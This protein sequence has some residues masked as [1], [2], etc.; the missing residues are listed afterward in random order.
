MQDQNP[1]KTD[2]TQESVFDPN[3]NLWDEQTILKTSTPLTRGNGLDAWYQY[4]AKHKN[5]DYRLLNTLELFIF[6]LDRFSIPHEF[7][8]IIA[9]TACT[10]ASIKRT[11]RTTDFVVPSPNLIKEWLDTLG[12]HLT[13]PSVVT[14]FA[15][16]GITGINSKVAR[17][18]GLPLASHHRLPPKSARLSPAELGQIFERSAAPDFTHPVRPGVPLSKEARLQRFKRLS[19]KKKKAAFK[20]AAKNEAEAYE[21]A[22][23][24]TKDK[25]VPWCHGIQLITGTRRPSTALALLRKYLPCEIS[26]AKHISPEDAYHNVHQWLLRR[27]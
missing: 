26:E 10:R 24:Y 13:A 17:L 20:K 2:T 27:R 18:H 9:I 14:G 8:T 15:E 3:S 12:L 25:L 4:K 1:S 22:T 16:N 21:N 19:P 23:G 7:W 11:G 5:E 6:Y